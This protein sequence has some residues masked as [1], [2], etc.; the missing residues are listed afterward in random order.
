VPHAGFARDVADGL[1]VGAGGF[2]GI[3]D[4]PDM[5]F[6]TAFGSVSAAT[7]ITLQVAEA[8]CPPDTADAWFDT[9]V[10]QVLAGAADFAISATIGA[11]FARLK[12]SAAVTL[13]ATIAGKR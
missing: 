6:V 2:S 12:S 13:T 8:R 10:T 4:M 1:A 3:I 9:Q 11:R 7:T 5:P